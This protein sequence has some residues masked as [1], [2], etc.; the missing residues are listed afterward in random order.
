MGKVAF[1]TG[2]TR[3]IGKQ[4]AIT[5]AKEGTKVVANYN[6]SENSALELQ[7]Y[8]ARFLQVL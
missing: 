8:L 4:I 1:I 6:K 5:L 3:G 2:A 7:K